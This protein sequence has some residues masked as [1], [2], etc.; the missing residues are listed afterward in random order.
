[1]AQ[2]GYTPISIYYSSTSTNV[3][4][5]GNLVAGELA[6][7]TADGKLFYKDSAGVVQVIGTKGGVGSSTTTQVLYNSS[8]LVVG[9]ANMTFSGTALTLANDASISGLT[10]GKGGS[11]VATNNALG[12]S[13]LSANTSGS[14]NTALGYNA[15]TSNTTGAY[16][17]FAGVNAGQQLVSGSFNTA[18]GNGSLNGASGSGNYNTAVGNSALAANTTASNNTAVGYQSLYANT[19]S[20]NTAIGYQA[21][22]ATTTGGGTV[23][24]GNVALTTNTTGDQNTAIGA[25]ALKLNTTGSYNVAL[26]YLALQANTTASNHTAVGYQAGYSKTSGDNFGSV[27]VGYNAGYQISTGTDNTIIGAQAGQAITTAYNNTAIG[28]AALYSNTAN[29]NTAVGYYAGYSSTTGLQNTFIGSGSGNAITT[30]GKN[31]IL[32]CYTG[33]SGGLDIRTASNFIVLS[34]GD[35]NPRQFVDASGNAWIGAYV[36]ADA[37]LNIAWTQGSPSWGAKFHANNSGSTNFIEFRLN[38]AGGGSTVGSITS[39]GS[40]TTYGTSSDYRLK[41][42]IVPMANALAKVSA[43]KPCT[44]KWKTD[45]S[46][47]EGFI[48]HELA[49]VCPDAVTGE[50]DAVNK[51][52]SIKPQAID[53][54]FLV[55]TLVSA[56]QELKAEIDALKGAK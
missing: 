8:G 38:L 27:F 23:A 36:G 46:N 45:G 33:N 9:S 1:M 26:G 12:T 28:G 39:N 35:G 15:G 29:S 5:A 48:A 16:N 14:Q 24:L 52:G 11:A 55:A 18:L 2:T 3:P 22:T 4:T 56:I 40:T 51:D 53:T 43:L 6:I 50:K 30:G 44:Y 10:V 25:G 7:N 32:G 34:D 20:G 42:N 54:S 21:A 17:L 41:E 37:R 47:G 31:T 49:E 13:A 19:N